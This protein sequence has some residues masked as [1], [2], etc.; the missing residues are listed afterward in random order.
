ML[1]RLNAIPP[2][3]VLTLL[4]AAC[5]LVGAAAWYGVVF[6]LE[7]R[8]GRLIAVAVLAHLLA[9]AAVDGLARI[10]TRNRIDADRPANALESPRSG[11]DRIAPDESG[12]P[13]PPGFARLPDRIHASDAVRE[14][15]DRD[16]G[17]ARSGRS[18]R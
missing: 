15:P 1:E 5:V 11:P 14:T 4:M 8:R 13:A 18:F 3:I 6:V 17:R 2:S 12:I 16:A 7:R 9:F 10:A